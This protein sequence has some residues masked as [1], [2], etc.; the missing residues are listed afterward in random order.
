M[1]L[2]QDKTSRILWI[3]ICLGLIGGIGCFTTGRVITPEEQTA[4]QHAIDEGNRRRIEALQRSADEGDVLA[5]TQLGIDYV[6]GNL[7]L[8]QDAPR[9]LSLLEKA[10]TKRYAPA[11]YTMGWLYLDGRVAGNARHI[12]SDLV[13]HN[14]TRGI[15]L[16]KQSASQACTPSPV[17]IFSQTADEISS[18]YRE[19]RLL[20]VD[21][22]QADLWLARSILH[23]QVPYPQVF[24]NKFLAP[25]SI[26]PQSQI[27]A[28][29]WMLL[30]PSSE[31][32]SK[33]QSTMS[34]E[35][36]QV[37]TDRSQALRRAVVESEKQYPA[38][39]HPGKP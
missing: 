37:A 31:V 28:M 34:Q 8:V 36:M 27:D 26:K 33:L 38:P 18:L 23:C 17:D 32:I 2:S 11:E 20:D 5:E 3:V 1:H 7:G 9:G 6:N 22:K 39:P 25:N 10:L 21:I 14:P 19:G 35:A 24:I 16:L 12:A 4:A 30:M 13:S 29:T 15:E